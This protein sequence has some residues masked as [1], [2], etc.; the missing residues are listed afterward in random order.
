MSTDTQKEKKKMTGFWYNLARQVISAAIIF[1]IIYGMHCSENPKI[2]NYAD[3]I[4]RAIRHDADIRGSIS[5]IS[6]RIKDTFSV[7]SPAE[8]PPE[9]ISFQ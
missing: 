7:D 9:G 4:G 8:N 1:A 5:N 2:R 3:S 6:T